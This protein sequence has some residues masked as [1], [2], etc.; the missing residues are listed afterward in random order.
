M[1]Q[2]LL[3]NHIDESLYHCHQYDR[4]KDKANKSS[5]GSANI[6]STSIVQDWNIIEDDLSDSGTAIF[7]DD[8]LD[9]IVDTPVKIGFPIAGAFLP[10]SVDLS[11]FTNS[12]PHRCGLRIYKRQNYTQSKR[13]NSIAAYKQQLT[14]YIPPTIPVSDLPTTPYVDEDSFPLSPC[15]DG[16]N[17]ALTASESSI[18]DYN[19]NSVAFTPIIAW[20]G[21][22][23]QAKSTI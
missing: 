11:R 6:R 16:D 22:M 8:S 2:L 18:E 13:I 7:S 23:S 10:E 14:T 17:M 3:P 4:A 9:S 1:N 15:E 20:Y 12:Y 5:A 21:A 19:I